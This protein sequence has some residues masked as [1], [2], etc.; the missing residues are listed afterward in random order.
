MFVFGGIHVIAELVCGCPKGFF[1]FLLNNYGP[2][3]DAIASAV[4]KYQSQPE[5]ETAIQLFEASE[6]RRQELLR[7]LN[8]ASGATASLVA[9]RSDLITFLK[10]NPALKAV[11]RDFYHLLS[12]WFNRGFLVLR[13]IDWNTPAIILEKIIL[14]QVELVLLLTTADD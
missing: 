5:D 10:D 1:E 7:R 9:M 3:H 6:P 11:D 2:D 4:Q 13:R 8:L 12:S 14:L